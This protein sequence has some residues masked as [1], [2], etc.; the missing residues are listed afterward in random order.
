MRRLHRRA[1]LANGMEVEM[2]KIRTHWV[3]M[4]ATSVTAVL[5]AFGCTVLAGLTLG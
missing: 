5:L 4:V 1:V 2:E 3:E